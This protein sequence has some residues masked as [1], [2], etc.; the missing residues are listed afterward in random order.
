MCGIAGAVSLGSPLRPDD[1]EAVAR[2]TRAMMHRGPDSS[3]R[4]D[5]ERISLSCARLR[6]NDLS[7]AAD[8]PMSSADGSV[9]L[10]YNGAVTNFRELA[11]KFSLASAGPL[12][13]SSDAEVVMRLYEKLGIGMLDELSGQFAF[14]L[15]DR[16]LGKAFLVRD[17]FGIRPLFTAEHG[18]KLY[19]ASEIKGLLEVPGWSRALDTEAFWHYFSL[20][21]IPGDRTPYAGVREI[22]GGRL[23]EIDIASGRRAERGYYSPDLTPDHSLTEEG[24]AA[25]VRRL[26]RGA[27]ER[28]L[29]CDAPAG[30]TL[31]GGVDTSVMLGLAKESGL[32]RGLHTF[33]IR[34]DEP[35]FDET[36]YQR[37]MAAYAGSVHHEIKVGP[38]E[39]LDCLLSTAAHLDEPTGDGAAAP[40]FLLARE[41]SRHVKV[42]LSGEGGDEIFSAYETHRACRARAA[43]RKWVP[44]PLRSAARRLAGGLPVS[45]D[46][47]SFDFLAKRFTAGAELGVPESHYFWRHS[48]AEEEKASLLSCPRPAVSTPGLFREMFDSLSYEDDLSR[49]AAID[50]R[51][52][53]IDDLMVKNDRPVMASSVETRFPYMEKDVASF[54]LRVPPALKVRGL[55]GRLVQKRAFRGLV[56]DKILSRRNMG[57]EM[58]H[59]LWFFGGFRALAEKYFSRDSVEG[60]GMLRHS[61]VERLWHE[62]LSRRRDNGRLLWCVLNFIIWFDL[63]VREGNYK[64]Y[65][66]RPSAGGRA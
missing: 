21:Y 26:M 33:S 27:V 10:S 44:S 15:Y 22:S 14:C 4:L 41:A 65:L 19:F 48:A 54:A 30:M 36:P 61:A 24:S 2:M 62:H 9:W 43:W 60:T 6:I 38:G 35:S 28:S 66:S 59:S 34:M 20:A 18:G 23:V 8:L 50:L 58:P 40:S 52:Y 37:L 17:F 3:G 45:N 39:V 25:E 53:F 7:P 13:T 5:D 32:S 11:R 63:F 55:S 49:L 56:P 31:S 42:L 47:L 1:R 12:R 16:R 51:Y 46:K 29:D 64:D 57:L